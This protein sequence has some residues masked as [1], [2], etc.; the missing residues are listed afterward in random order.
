[1]L[2]RCHQ[3]T[4]ISPT[5][6]RIVSGSDDNVLKVWDARSGRLVRHLIGPDLQ[7][8]HARDCPDSNGIAAASYDETCSI[9]DSPPARTRSLSAATPPMLSWASRPVP[10][11]NAPPQGDQ[12]GFVRLGTAPWS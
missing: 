5:A 6:C 11:A 2:R 10:T 8:S 3:P 12:N 1:M 4:C 9:W 7:L